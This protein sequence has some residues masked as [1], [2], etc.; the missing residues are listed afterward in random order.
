MGSP[1]SQRQLIASHTFQPFRRS[2]LRLLLHGVIYFLR[3]R[4]EVLA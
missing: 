2:N 1:S 3:R 4:P